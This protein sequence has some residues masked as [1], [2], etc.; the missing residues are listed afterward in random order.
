MNIKT[1]SLIFVSLVVAFSLIA[2][3][4]GEAVLSAFTTPEVAEGVG[5]AASGAVEAL[6]S[7][8]GPTGII[9]GI[10]AVLGPV[11]AGVAIKLQSNEKK[12]PSRSASEVEDLKL[13]VVF[14]QERVSTL[15]SRL[16]ELEASP[17]VVVNNNS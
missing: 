8:V 5:V 10:V 15:S 6:G 4:F 13:E 7:G 3:A 11:L 14:Q 9:T 2:C 1:I 12:K 17:P 16:S